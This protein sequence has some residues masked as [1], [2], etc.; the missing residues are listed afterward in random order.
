MNKVN[1]IVSAYNVDKFIHKCIASVLRQTYEDYKLI[2][3]ND[4]STDDTLKIAQ[5]FQ[6]KKPDKIEIHSK[7]NGGLSSAR[8][9]G[10]EKS[11]S[12]YVVFL[13]GDD[14]L[15]ENYLKTLT[16]AAENSNMD[17][18][19]SGQYRV[20]R[21]GN[22]LS[23][24]RYMLDTNGRCVLR[25]LN[26]HGKLYRLSY[27]NKHNMRFPEGKTYEDNPFNMVMFFMTE[28]IVFLDYEGYY[29]VVHPD[30]ITAR[31]IKEEEIPFKE[32][33]ESIRYIMRHKSLINNYKI[34]EYTVMSFFTYFI[35]E[36][37]KKHRF[38]KCVD[39]KSDMKVVYRLC[40]F[41]EH[42][43]QSYFMNYHKNPYLSIVRKND[44]G[45]KQ[46]AGVKLF[47]LLLR[48]GML[49]PAVRFF[50]KI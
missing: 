20:D 26:M 2:I 40:D 19:C 6:A 44:I 11:E 16:E 17:V 28:K 25:H 49:K 42:I 32:F 39:R 10:L 47:V 7:P 43:L 4:G 8:N 15:D 14:Y 23:A 1:V 33:E 9:Y 27:I 37:N 13:D 48:M 35:F 29:Q 45:I 50:Y 46:K 18:V 22:V 3:V 5:Q 38:Y 12:E 41:A 24:V 30:S 31:K 21:K 34:L 36:A